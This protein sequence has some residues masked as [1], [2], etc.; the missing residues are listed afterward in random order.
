M[1]NF[2]EKIKNF[3]SKHWLEAINFIVVLTLAISLST[4]GELVMTETLANVWLFVLIAYYVF[5]KLLWKR[6][7]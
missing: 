4:Y 1:E 2:W 3:F 5:Y 6:G 7:K